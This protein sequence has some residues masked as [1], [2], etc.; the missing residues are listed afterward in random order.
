MSAKPAPISITEP[1]TKPHPFWSGAFRPLFLFAGILAIVAVIWWVASF[2]HGIPVPSL[3]TPSYWHA[4]EMIFGFGGA[5]IG[6]FLLTAIANWTG[7]PA[8]AGPMLMALTSTWLL[9]RFAIGFAESLPPVAVI[10]GALAYFAFLI[11]LG[12]R[13]LIAARNL[14]NMRVLAVICVLA[15]FDGLFIASCLDVIALDP[16]MLYQTAILTIILLIALIGGRVIPAFTRNWMQREQIAA[17]LPV[18][19]GRFDMACLAS[20]ALAIITLITNPEAALPGYVLL[21][22]SVLHGVRLIRWR[23][24]YSWREPIV[25]MLHLGYFWVPVGL[26]LLGASM[27]WPDA[28]GSRDALHG[29]TGGAMACMIIAIAGRAALGHTG[30]ELRA[31]TMLNAAFGLIWFSTAFRILAGQSNAHYLTILA[32]ATLMWLAGWL[33]FLIGYAPVLLGPSQKKTR[34]I[35]VR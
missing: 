8:I 24:V 33:A 15:L 2:A 10:V 28:I 20:I 19:F 18:L 6:G 32:I 13:E 27:I 7:R 14:K 1:A 31:S 30:R 29:L 3:G 25:A 22:A 23:G 17:P 12:A 35:P 34:G 16:M 11:A 9:G 21:I 4:H 26:G 5:A